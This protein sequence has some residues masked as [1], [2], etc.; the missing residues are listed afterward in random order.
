MP[1]EAPMSTAQQLLTAFDAL[2]VSEQDVVVTELLAR[3]PVGVGD[4]PDATFDELADE[5]FQSY[6]AEETADATPP[7]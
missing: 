7:G 2:P 3:R 1:L 5:L 4:L 6:D